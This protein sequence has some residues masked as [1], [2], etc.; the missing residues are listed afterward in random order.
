MYE[1]RIPTSFLSEV[2][3]P[4]H[5]LFVVVNKFES[6]TLKDFMSACQKVI[7]TGMDFLP[8]IV[9]SYGG[10][11]YTL[12]GM[13]DFLQN[14]GVKVITICEAKAMSC[15][16][17]LF[18]CGDERYMGQTATVMIHE[19]ST[20][21][22][23]KNVELQNE[24]KEVERLNDL[25]FGILDKN[26]KQK[27]GFWWDKVQKNKNTDLFLTSKQAK[28]HGLATHVGIPYIETKVDVTRTLK[29][30]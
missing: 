2:K 6:Y 1:K 25:V 19:V 28:T 22:Y 16:A 24:A 29:V 9:D 7:Q 12:L 15:G 30:K 8:I 10:E 21:F 20:W 17:L 18:S 3:F 4:E 23:G 27:K 13:I 11:I 5:D 14:C 26:T